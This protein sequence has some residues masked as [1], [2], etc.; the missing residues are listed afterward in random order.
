M[1]E[2][3]QVRIDARFVKSYERYVDQDGWISRAFVNYYAGAPDGKHTLMS[4]SNPTV[5]M[6]FFMVFHCFPR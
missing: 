3:M 4:A 6:F 2:L 5:R 1:Q